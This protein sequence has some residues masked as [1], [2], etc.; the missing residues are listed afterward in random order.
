MLETLFT[1]TGKFTRNV[2]ILLIGSGMGWTGA[3][4]CR[5][6]IAADG[7]HIRA[8]HRAHVGVVATADLTN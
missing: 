1:R 7:I 3:M 5:P 4:A 2:I 8:I 6:P